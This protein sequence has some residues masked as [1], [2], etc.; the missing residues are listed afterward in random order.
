MIG[1]NIPWATSAASVG[2]VIL[3]SAA[4]S[5]TWAKIG[6]AT[7]SD[8]SEPYF[9]QTGG[10]NIAMGTAYWHRAQMPVMTFVAGQDYYASIFLRFGSSGLVR[11]W[12]YSSATSPT[13][14]IR[15]ALDPNGAIVSQAEGN[16]SIFAT[17]L[18]DVDGTVKRLDFG[19]Q[20]D[21]DVTDG[22]CVNPA[23]N[24]AGQDVVAY[25]GQISTDGFFADPIST[26]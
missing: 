16:G 14:D 2:G 1:V 8:L 6:G 11:V 23:G 3:G 24:A 19:F 5:A 9:D 13:T 20:V 17:D 10:L 18:V 7:L 21:A 4:S 12:L 22:L 25:H 26:S 15:V